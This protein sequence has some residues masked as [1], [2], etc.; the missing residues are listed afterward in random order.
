[1]I[2]CLQQ[3]SGAPLLVDEHVGLRQQCCSFFFLL[4]YLYYTYD[5][6][7]LIYSKLL[8]KVKGKSLLAGLF[9]SF[10]EAKPFDHYVKM[11]ITNLRCLLKSI[12]GLLK[13][14]CFPNIFKI[15]K[16]FKL[17]HIK[18]L[19][20]IDARNNVSHIQRHGSARNKVLYFSKK[21]GSARNNV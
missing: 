9:F 14:A 6:L 5:L 10:D 2:A 4:H 17:C 20:Q 15:N 21:H 1:M 8:E 11:K 16:T 12:D 19:T 18:I 13:L 3:Q 7:L